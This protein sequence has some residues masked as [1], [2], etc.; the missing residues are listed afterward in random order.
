MQQLSLFEQPV[1]E[2]PDIKD[3]TIEWLYNYIKILYPQ[4]AFAKSFADGT[5]K[6]TQTIS[7]K[8]DLQIS[9]GN[10]YSHVAIIG[11]QPYI[12]LSYG[13]NYGTYEHSSR[14][15]LTTEEFFISLK[16]AVTKI[17]EYLNER[18]NDDR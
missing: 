12:R 14:P 11:G 16:T 13:K 15:C 17:E 4:F 9:A 18:V 10:F 3:V 5:E 7:K 6:I 2:L 8:I 1:E